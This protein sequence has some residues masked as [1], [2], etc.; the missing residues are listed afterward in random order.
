MLIYVR[1]KSYNIT[2]KIQKD[3]VI[4]KGL[5]PFVVRTGKNL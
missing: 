2:V 3:Y 5:N 1:N 4:S